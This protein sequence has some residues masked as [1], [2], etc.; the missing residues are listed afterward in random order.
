MRDNRAIRRRLA[1]AIPGAVIAAVAGLHWSGEIGRPDA[2]ASMMS[3]AP[4]PSSPQSNRPAWQTS[5]PSDTHRRN[6]FLTR[7][8]TFPRDVGTLQQPMRPGD[9]GA[10]A[11]SALI[12]ADHNHDIPQS[13]LQAEVSRI[14]LQS[15]MM[16]PVPRALVDGQVVGEGGFVGEFR[17]VRIEL[18]R[19][20]LER[21]GFQ[22]RI[23][24]K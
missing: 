13:S 2:R 6:L 20:V 12:P 14:H 19:I 23:T 16:H 15:T 8:D 11:K 5:W 17:V 21:Q 24:L 22:F 3:S 1:I 4:M 9:P 7:L 10:E 18:S